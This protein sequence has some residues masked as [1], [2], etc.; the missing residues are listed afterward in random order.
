MKVVTIAGVHLKKDEDF[1]RMEKK[2]KT[3]RRKV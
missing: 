1:S 3:K 2:S